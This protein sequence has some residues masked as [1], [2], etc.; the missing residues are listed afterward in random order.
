MS[1]LPLFPLNTVL[2]PGMPISLHIFE[3]RYKLM[4]NR[5]I[6][7]QT[8]FGVV[9]LQAGSEVQGTGPAAVPY[10]MGCAAYIT[11]VQRL[12]LG[13]LNLIAIG[14][15]RFR[16][17]DL[18]YTEP[19]LT[20]TVEYLTL[21]NLDADTIPVLDRSLRPWV[22]RYLSAIARAENI[23]FDRQQL[24]ADAVQLAYLAASLARI[25]ANDKQ[26]LLTINEAPTLIERILN[27]Y[28]KE[29]TLLNVLLSQTDSA[30]EPQ[31]G[32]FSI[33]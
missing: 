6:D 15:E 8:P 10:S 7:A 30:I 17:T 33:N 3:D 16:I 13:R 4:I 12:N 22:E 5:C 20:G 28:R 9:L 18:T 21:N 26:M 24:P 25:P 19:Y 2:F 11:Q 27:L 31:S 32:V 14:G 29:T 1:S 23:Q